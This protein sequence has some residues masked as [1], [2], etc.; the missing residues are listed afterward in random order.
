MTIRRVLRRYRDIW[1]LLITG[2]VV[3]S[4]HASSQEG[5]S[6]RDQNCLVFERMWK[7]DVK[8]LGSTYDYL[9]PLSRKQMAEP[10]NVA[11]LRNLPR[12]E[13]D[14]KAERPPVYCKGN[15]GL[16]DSKLPKVPKRPR[17]LRQG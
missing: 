3:W 6:R 9:R 14:I 7:S 10:L 16:A 15:V 11:I 5:I 12:T 2:F 17:N 8:R 1:L 13:D 4:L